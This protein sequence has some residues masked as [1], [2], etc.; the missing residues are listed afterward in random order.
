MRH[1]GRW[2][3][4]VRVVPCRVGAAPWLGRCATSDRAGGWWRSR[5]TEAR[6]AARATTG[7]PGAAASP[8]ASRH[9]WRRSGS[10]RALRHGGATGRYTAHPQWSRCRPSRGRRYSAQCL[11][12]RR[13]WSV[14]GFMVSRDL[15]R[16][17]R[18][19]QRKLPPPAL[20]AVSCPTPTARGRSEGAAK[21]RATAC[22]RER[23]PRGADERSEFRRERNRHRVYAAHQHIPT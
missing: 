6:R 11:R 8:C 2:P 13:R 5:Y 12:G 1:P 17:P 22:R 7:R 9:D 10:R 20:D 18:L 14:P 23:R 15:S 3:V 16:H 4:H 19:V 21:Q